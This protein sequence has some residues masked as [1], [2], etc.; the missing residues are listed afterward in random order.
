MGKFR[1]SGLK[2]LVA[3][4]VA[5]RGIDVDDIEVVVNYDLPY[6]PEDYVHRIGRTARAGRD[7]VAVSFCSPAEKAFL[8]DVERLIRKR[9]HILPTPEG[10]E[11]E[12]RKRGGGGGGGGR[13][14]H[15]HGRQGHGG[16]H[17]HAGHG[18]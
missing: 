16:G 9:V 15:Q 3:T 11:V 10:L 8:S 5:A 13:G 18:H 12:S 7:G 1:K 2:F 14:R 6:V 17:G 4:D